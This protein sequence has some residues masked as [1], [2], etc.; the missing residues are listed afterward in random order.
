MRDGIGYNT[1]E[2]LKIVSG[3]LLAIAI[4]DLL[5]GEKIFVFIL[6]LIIYLIQVGF[7]I[8]QLIIGIS[9]NTPESFLTVGVL[10]RWWG[11][12]SIW[13]TFSLSGKNS[14]GICL[15]FCTIIIGNFAMLT[16]RKRLQKFL[17]TTMPFAVICIYFSHSRTAILC[18]SVFILIRFWRMLKEGKLLLFMFSVVSV[19]S[20]FLIYIIFKTA[21]SWVFD[22]RSLIARLLQQKHALESMNSNIFFGNGYNSVL[23][24][25]LNFS[26]SRSLINSSNIFLGLSTDNFFLR[27]FLETGIL[28]VMSFIYFLIHLLKLDGPNILPKSQFEIERKLLVKQI[29]ITLFFACL[30]FDYFSN[31]T[32]VCLLSLL[33]CYCVNMCEEN[34]DSI[35]RRRAN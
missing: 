15:A 11:F 7:G 9:F 2:G 34:S 31:Q 23:S 28:G 30:S 1:L 19:F 4:S 29:W 22:S 12:D 27:R 26:G 13:G 18:L 33:L 24:N 20:I 6:I 14:Y 35:K 8:A 32:N 21:P 10:N 3:I 16:S 5:R 17:F 25:S